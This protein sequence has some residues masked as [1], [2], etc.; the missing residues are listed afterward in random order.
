MPC[1]FINCLAKGTCSLYAS[2]LPMHTDCTYSENE[3]FLNSP[4]C[5]LKYAYVQCQLQ[6]FA[7]EYKKKVTSVERAIRYVRLN[8][9]EKTKEMFNVNYKIDNGNFI[10]LL[11][12]EIERNDL[13]GDVDEMHALKN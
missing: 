9:E 12:R 1:A 3:L 7:N 8:V 6:Y 10:A 4:S 11:A 5:V 13:L 2:A